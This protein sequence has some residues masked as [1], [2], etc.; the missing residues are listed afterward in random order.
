MLELE[1]ERNKIEFQRMK[2]MMKE[3]EMKLEKE[4]Q[5]QLEMIVGWML[6]KKTEWD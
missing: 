4:K 1:E 6:M 5:D 3:K 2:K